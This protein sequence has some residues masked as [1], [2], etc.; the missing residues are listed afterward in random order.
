MP[1]LI[2]YF[3]LFFLLMQVYFI[4]KNYLPLLRPERKPKIILGSVTVII[5]AKN[6]AQ[7][8]AENLP[9][10]LEQRYKD[11]EVI[12]MDDHSSDQTKE[13]IL[14]LCKKHKKLRYLHA[15]EEIEHKAG[16][17]WAL[18]RLRAVEIH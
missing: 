2:Y 17:K 7:Q 1:V 8:L 12:V 3:F 13:L 9:F 15:S 11:F 6:E 14:T 18:I 5:C 4:Y 10:I 16:K